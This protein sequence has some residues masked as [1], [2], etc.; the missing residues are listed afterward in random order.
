M[1]MEYDFMIDA[2][3]AKGVSAECPACGSLDS[4]LYTNTEKVVARFLV[5][6]NMD[7]GIEAVG[8][9]CNNCGHV[10]LFDADILASGFGEPTQ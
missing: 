6:V 10:R 8:L 2:L 7:S 3:A 9:S 5:M 4:D 1:T